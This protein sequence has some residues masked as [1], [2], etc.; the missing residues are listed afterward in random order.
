MILWLIALLCILVPYYVTHPSVFRRQRVL[1]YVVAYL[2]TWVFSVWLAVFATV[3]LVI[4]A[5]AKLA[6]F[7]AQNQQW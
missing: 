3:A 4:L 2:L 1:V 7:D 6:A 5:V